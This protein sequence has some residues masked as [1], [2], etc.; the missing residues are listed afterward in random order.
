MRVS[1]TTHIKGGIIYDKIDEIGKIE[2][3]EKKI[4]LNSDRKRMWFS[5]LESLNE[6][7]FCDSV[8]IPIDLVGDIISKNEVTWLGYDES[9]YAP[10]S[11]L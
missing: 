8:P 4:G 3:Y 6:K 11:E 10:E 7:K 9:A 1:K 2:I 5:D